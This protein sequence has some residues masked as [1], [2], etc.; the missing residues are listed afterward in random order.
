MKHYQAMD[1]IK[2]LV[3]S[4]YHRLL[5]PIIDKKNEMDHMANKMNL[6]SV[7][8]K[9]C[10]INNGGKI[11]NG[12][13]EHSVEDNERVGVSHNST[14][15]AGARVR[16]AFEYA[17]NILHINYIELVIATENWSKENILG[18]GGFGIVYKGKWKQTE[19]AI[20]KMQYKDQKSAQAIRIQMQQSL[21]ELRH[22][23][24]FRHDNILPVYGYSVHEEEPC[25]VYQLMLGGSLEHRL[26]AKP[27]VDP[28]NWRQ[29]LNIARGTARGLQFL[30][31]VAEKPL[32]HG[33]IKPAN[34]L[35]DPCCMPKI[36]D[37]GLAR[38][39]PHATNSEKVVSQVYGTLPYLA[40]EFIREKRLS[41]KVDTY[42]FGVVLFELASGL[43]AYERERNPKYLA[44][45]MKALIGGG[46]P[47]YELRDK[48]CGSI[49]DD[50]HMAC[51]KLMKL[52]LSCTAERPENRPEMVEVLTELERN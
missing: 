20:K 23:N 22:L 8:S 19:V 18:R 44:Y 34:I 10:K 29:R 38:E 46:I 25:L 32:I 27:M 35:L 40:P 33:D 48:S 31:T 6:V 28:L 24:S 39:G 30:H 17:G 4:G 3:D 2:S 15:S 49:E 41:T 52:G 43:R 16:H 13:A 9:V 50:V 12:P 51:E 21:N 42:G 45:Y 14:V 11:L 7:S 1:A 47:F 37:F 5:Q 36:A 26:Y